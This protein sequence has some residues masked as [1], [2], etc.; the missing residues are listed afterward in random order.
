VAILEFNLIAVHSYQKIG[1]VYHEVITPPHEYRTLLLDKLEKKPQNINEDE[2]LITVYTLHQDYIPKVTKTL[3]TIKDLM[4]GDK[5]TNVHLE[6]LALI[7]RLLEIDLLDTHDKEIV[8]SQEGNYFLNQTDSEKMCFFL[9]PKKGKNRLFSE[10][11]QRQIEKELLSYDSWI[12]VDDF[13]SSL[14]IPL[15][16][17]APLELI[18]KGRNTFYAIP[19]YNE[20]ER[21][22]IRTFL[23]DH[24]A[25]ANVIELGESEG[26]MTLR[27]TKFGRDTLN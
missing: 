14:Q 24:L 21:A 27:I 19:V 26:K 7:K 4:S 20:E 16:T 10:W 11:V 9:N 23:C 3:K 12:Y 5:Q 1:D 25:V 8:V 18:R 2:K 13:I 17:H 6:D 22:S 15:D